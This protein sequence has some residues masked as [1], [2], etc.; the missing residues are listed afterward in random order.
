MPPTVHVSEYDVGRT[1]NIQLIGE[2]GSAFEIPT[3]TTATVEGTLNGTVGFTTSATISNN[4]ITFALTESMTAYSGKAWCKIKLTLN[5]EPIQTCAFILAVDRAGVE[6]DT[7]IGAPGFEE[8]IVDAVQDWLDEHPP[9]SGGVTEEFKQALLDCFEHVAWIDDQG[10]DYYDALYAALY[11]P[12]DVLSISA[13]FTQGSAVIYDTDSLDDLKQ[14]LVVTAT[15]TDSTTQ[16]LEDTD[17]TLSGTLAVGTSTIT[18]SYGGKTTTF[19]VTV[20][21]YNPLPSGYTKYDYI[22]SDG[23]AYFQLSASDYYVPV[24]YT[25]KVVAQQT[26]HNASVSSVV[27]GGATGNAYAGYATYSKNAGKAGAYYGAGV[28]AYADVSN[29]LTAKT[30]FITKFTSEQVSVTITNSGNTQTI[31]EPRSSLEFQTAT[32]F[33]VGYNA[34][35]SGYYFVGKIYLIEV[36]DGSDN[37]VHQFIPCVRTSDSK[38]GLYDL[39]GNTFHYSDTSTPFVAG[40]D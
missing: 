29:L 10:Q 14:Y 26:T 9:A 2:N 31:T 39:V 36:I 30:E 3:G 27:C 24:G 37:L 11:P 19:N 13:V 28:L 5:S 20:T 18:V 34:G 6:A 40:N 33:N 23:N 12:V 15:M 22:S 25:V 38:A 16:T 32:R 8:Q 35:T 7:V 21:E 1:Y 4:Q 17:Y